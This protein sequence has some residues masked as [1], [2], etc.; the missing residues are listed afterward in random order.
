MSGQV[1]DQVGRGPVRSRQGGRKVYN[2]DMASTEFES[3]GP[4]ES[5]SSDNGERMGRS[6][7]GKRVL[8]RRRIGSSG[9]VV[10]VD[11]DPRPEVPS[12][13]ITTEWGPANAA[14]DRLMKAY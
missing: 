6:S 9:Y 12:E 7:G 3:L 13:M 10:S 11:A 8:M 5:T 1:G 4:G 2:G 14:F